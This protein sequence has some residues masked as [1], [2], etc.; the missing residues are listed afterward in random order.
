MRCM[1]PGYRHAAFLRGASCQPEA[2]PWGSNNPVCN[3]ND[4]NLNTSNP[5]ILYGALA[6]GAV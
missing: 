1:M 6:G 3:Y 4:F 2:Q 5:S